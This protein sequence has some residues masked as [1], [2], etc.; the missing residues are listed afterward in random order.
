MVVQSRR[1]NLR[2]IQFAEMSRY[3]RYVCSLQ[4]ILPTSAN[5]REARMPYAQVRYLPSTTE[6]GSN[7]TVRIIN[8]PGE[9]PRPSIWI[10]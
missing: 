10:S 8:V 7:D 3:L 2:R 6:E 1:P 4:L 9:D 5:S